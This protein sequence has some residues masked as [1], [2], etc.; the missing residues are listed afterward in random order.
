M[1]IL[2]IDKHS[3]KNSIRLSLLEQMAHH[4]VHLSEEYDN[5]MTYYKEENPDIVLIDFSIDFGKE[6]LESILKIMPK[7]KI[8]TLSDSLD[9]SE[10]LGCDSCLHHY[11]KRRL[12]KHHGIH[13]LLYLIDNFKETPCEYA[14][15]FGE[16]CLPKAIDA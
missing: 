11:D 5:A 10:A 3:I 14:H 12:V 8:I 6:A 16:D 2:F 9:C 15:R 4:R 13:E 1:K 7:Q